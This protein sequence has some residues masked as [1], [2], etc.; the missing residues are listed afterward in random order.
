MV[1]LVFICALVVPLGIFWWLWFK[2]P[3]PMIWWTGFYSI[4]IVGIVAFAWAAD[5]PREYAFLA[6]FFVGVA[7][8]RNHVEW[9][10]LTRIW[11]RH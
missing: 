9:A 2:E 10:V 7:A 5:A 8:I 3:S 6:F 11:R 1:A 4:I